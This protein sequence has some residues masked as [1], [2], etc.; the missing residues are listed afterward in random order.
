MA[1]PG[2]I[3]AVVRT[4]GK[5]A[6]LA[7]RGVEVRTADY[8]RPETLASAFRAG[9]RLL[10]ISAYEVGRRV[11]QHAA[12]IDAAEAAGV[13]QLA[14]TGMLGGPAADFAL[15]DEHK[16]TEQLDSRLRTALHVPAQQPVLGGVHREPRRRA[17]ARRRCGP[18]RHGTSRLGIP[19][20]P[21]GRG[22]RR[23][24]RRGSPRPGLRAQRRHGMVVRGVRG[25]GSRQT[26]RT[27]TYDDVS[28]EARLAML[29]GAGLP[30]PVASVLVGMEGAIGRGLLAATPGDLARLIGRPTTPIA[31]SIAEALKGLS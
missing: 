25:G 30:E 13:A 20:R 19:P 14:Y 18:R 15:A 3:A 23:P 5:A 22:G 21:R 6:G 12:V 16:A 24:D 10:L 8:D 9:D 4:D 2:D 27:V 11:P 26:G 29:T 1:P 7:A 31:D 17:G 28:W